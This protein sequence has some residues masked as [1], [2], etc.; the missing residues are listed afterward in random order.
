MPPRRRS[1]QTK[2]PNM[3]QGGC[4]QS[5]LDPVEDV[6]TSAM[7]WITSQRRPYIRLTGS[8]LRSVNSVITLRGLRLKCTLSGFRLVVAEQKVLSQLTDYPFGILF[9]WFELLRPLFKTGRL[10]NVCVSV[11]VCVDDMAVWLYLLWI[12]QRCMQ[13]D[14]PFLSGVFLIQIFLQWD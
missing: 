9:V 11:L 2:G 7:W 5:N 1:C 3:W 8:A 6:C 12:Q 13:S 4:K 14:V 10:H